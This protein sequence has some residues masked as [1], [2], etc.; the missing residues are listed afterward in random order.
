MR[1]HHGNVHMCVDTLHPESPFPRAGAHVL[2]TFDQAVA[3]YKKE[4]PTP[5]GGPAGA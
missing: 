3:K 4:N 5:P 2:E 1:A